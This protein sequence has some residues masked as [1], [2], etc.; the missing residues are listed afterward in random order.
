M[1]ALI[2]NVCLTDWCFMIDVRPLY[3]SPVG[4]GGRAVYARCEV[5]VHEWPPHAPMLTVLHFFNHW[6]RNAKT[7]RSS[8]VSVLISLISDTLLIE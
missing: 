1:F 8:V 2:L 6:D 4:F 7:K 5:D 3:V